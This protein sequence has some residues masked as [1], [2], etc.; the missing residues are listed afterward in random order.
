M[1]KDGQVYPLQECLQIAVQNHEGLRTARKQIELALSKLDE[2]KR[3]LFPNATL[4]S[5]VT[6]GETRS[7]PFREK[8][9]IFRVEQPLFDGGGTKATLAQAQVNLEIARANYDKVMQDLRFEIEK[10]YYELAKLLLQLEIQTEA[11]RQSE[12][13][14]EMA[15]RQLEVDVITRLEHLNVQALYH[16]LL[17]QRISTE[18]DVTLGQMNLQHAMNVASE[19]AIRIDYRLT[20]PEWNRELPECQ[21]FAQRRR[22]EIMINYLLV[23]FHGYSRKIVE[24][25]KRWK[26]DLASSYGSS[27]S[28][29]KGE[30][31]SLGDDLFVGLQISRPVGLHSLTSSMTTQQT[32]AKLGQSDRTESEVISSEIGFFNQYGGISERKEADVSYYQAMGELEKIKKTV[33]SEVSE[34]Y[35]NGQKA[36][37]LYNAQKNRVEFRERGLSVVELQQRINE[38]LISNV[39]EAQIQLAQERI[40]LVTALADYHLSLASLNRTTG[41]AL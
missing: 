25:K 29:F 8:E 20:P 27:G 5:S 14:V 26:L 1:L 3:A 17:Y 6:R 9:Y 16:Q 23:K 33:E 38:A 40:A 21:R 2:S 37:V 22:P 32:A 19:P 34:A 11:V 41:Y 10:N 28:A 36:E 24:A 12:P 35:F 31:L 18:K 39:L 30:D 7:A 13:L 4:R 15:R